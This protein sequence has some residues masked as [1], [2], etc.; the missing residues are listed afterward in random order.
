MKNKTFSEVI[1]HAWTARFPNKKE[2]QMFNVMLGIVID[3]GVNPPSTSTAL[4]EWQLSENLS[5][6]IAAG[7][8]K[9]DDHHGGAIQPLIKILKSESNP[10]HIVEKHLKQ[11]KRLPGFGHRIYKVEDPRAKKL[12][13]TAKKLGFSGKY[14]K[15]VIELE[16]ELEAQK[17]KKLP[18]NVDGALAAI[19]CEMGFDEKLAN[20]F[21]ILPRVAGMIARVTGNLSS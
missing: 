2:L 8:S 9:I 11:E 5:K 12:F 1:F 17:Q 21:F 19:I 7:I 13:I 18:I 3:H 4:R 16:F 20:G 14:V 10:K 6:S 15:K